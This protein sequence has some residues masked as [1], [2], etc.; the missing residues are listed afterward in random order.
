MK[1]TFTI[2]CFAICLKCFAQQKSDLNISKYTQFDQ[3]YNYEKIIPDSNYK[4]WK[5]VKYTKDWQITK[6]V[7]NSIVYESGKFNRKRILKDMT[8]QQ[9]FLSG[10]GDIVIHYYIIALTLNNKIKVINN[11]EQLRRFIGKV[12][13]EEEAKLLGLAKGYSLNN[14]SP[15]FGS[16]LKTESGYLLYFCKK[17]TFTHVGPPISPVSVHTFLSTDGMFSLL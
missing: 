2:L 13:N 1:I 10:G 15:Y 14:T 11:D 12:D 5:V 8:S 16:Y 3:Q 9:G 6:R 7:T 4:Y 17:N